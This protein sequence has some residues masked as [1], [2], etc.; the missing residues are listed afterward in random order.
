M[1][2]GRAVQSAGAT[3]A[4]LRLVGRKREESGRR[5][6]EKLGYRGYDVVYAMQS[7]ARAVFDSA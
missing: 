3:D 2:A 1:L 6:R 7:K 5:S 4:A